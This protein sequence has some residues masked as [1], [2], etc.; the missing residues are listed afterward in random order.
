MANSATNRVRSPSPAD[1]PPARATGGAANRE[2]SQP[3]RSFVM[4]RQSTRRTDDAGPCLRVT[5]PRLRYETSPA[6]KAPEVFAHL[7]EA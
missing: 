2:G 6:L 4:T 7:V 1:D 5:Q 3:R